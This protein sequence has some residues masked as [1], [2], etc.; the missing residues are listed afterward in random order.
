[1]ARHDRDGVHRRSRV[2]EAEAASGGQCGACTVAKFGHRTRFTPDIGL[3]QT[4]GGRGHCLQSQ[5]GGRVDTEVGRYL[6]TAAQ[7]AWVNAGHGT[8]QRQ[9]GQVRAVFAGVQVVVKPK[10][11]LAIACG[12]GVGVSDGGAIQHCI[13]ERSGHGGC[14]VKVRV[15]CGQAVVGGC[16]VGTHVLQPQVVT[17]A[18]RVGLGDGAIGVATGNSVQHLVGEHVE[19]TH[20]HVRASPCLVEVHIG[21]DIRI[22]VGGDGGARDGGAVRRA[23]VD[24]VL[25]QVGVFLESTNVGVG[26]TRGFER[27]T[28]GATGADREVRLGGIAGEIGRRACDIKVNRQ[29]RRSV[30]GAGEGVDQIAIRV[31][32][33]PGSRC[34]R[35]GDVRQA[36]TG[37]RREVIIDDGGRHFAHCADV[38]V[39]VAGQSNVQRLIP[40]TRSATV[41]RA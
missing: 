2:G 12:L 29:L 6:V 39:G 34:E 9:A 28:C 10:V 1:M 16:Q 36:R 31:L 32:I 20:H 24:V 27:V 13:H 38:V 14:P 11:D 15:G 30:A 22:R 4:Q 19:V 33:H 18:L 7:G 25:D 37:A 35:Q 8:E 21:V 41:K 5:S 3:V 40:T 23:R 26:A 17:S